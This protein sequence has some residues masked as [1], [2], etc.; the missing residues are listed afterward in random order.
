M[1]LVVFAGVRTGRD[2]LYRNARVLRVGISRGGPPFAFRERH[3]LWRISFFHVRLSSVGL[4]W[5][6]DE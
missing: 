5:R 2:H 4:D 1:G 6:E 3:A